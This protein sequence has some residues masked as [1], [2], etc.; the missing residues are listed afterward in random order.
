MLRGSQDGELGVEPNS[1][2]VILVRRSATGSRDGELGKMPPKPFVAT[3]I[4]QLVER[5]AIDL[6][7]RIGEILPYFRLSDGGHHGITIRQVLDHTSGLPDLE[8]YEW[9]PPELDEGAAER[10]V[11]SI[12]SMELLFAPGSKHQYSN[13]AF[14]ALG[15][16][17]AKVSGVSFEEYMKTEILLPLGMKHSSFI[18]PEI[19]EDLRTTGHVGDP[20][21][22]S[23]VYPYN[24]R[25]AP[26][27]TLNS[28]IAD[29]TRWILANLNRGELD[30]HHILQPESF[31]LLWTPS[32]SLPDSPG[33][34]VG[35]SWYLGER[36]GIRIVQ[37]A[38]QDEGYSSDLFLAPDIGAG[39][40][41]VSNWDGDHPHDLCLDTLDMI[42]ASLDGSSD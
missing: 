2:S 29:M 26:S 23:E 20:A 33:V 25:H 31:D 15:D 24:R 9:D 34:T 21:R 13:L 12:A 4:V 7:D 28:S 5:Q 11:R 3:A 37:H 19:A 32:A 10:L 38:G 39:V 17:I 36:E 42:R 30:G 18:H 14:D 6:D 40:V 41:M 8:V 22:V 27:S 35:L 16:V 1:V